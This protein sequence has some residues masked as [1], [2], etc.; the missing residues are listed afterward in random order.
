M[1]SL[2][3]ANAA[4]GIDTYYGYGGLAYVTLSDLMG[5]QEVSFA[6][7]INGSW[8]NTN[9]AAQYHYLAKKMDY[10]VLGYH[11]AYQSSNIRFSSVDTARADSV[12]LDRQWG[13]GGS[14]S[15]PTSVYTRFIAWPCRTCESRWAVSSTAS[16]MATNPT[17]LVPMEMGISK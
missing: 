1:W 12:F 6:L 11:Q 3:N 16:P 8:E 5:D 4:L 15:Y 2:D 7:N 13:F 14:M 17:M 10:S 9:G